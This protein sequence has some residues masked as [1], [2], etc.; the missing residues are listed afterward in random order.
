[1]AITHN[2]AGRVYTV[3]TS[4]IISFRDS[5]ALSLKPICVQKIVFQPTA[6]TNTATLY[7]LNTAA[8]PDLSISPLECVVTGNDKF[9]DNVG[10]GFTATSMAVITSW[11]HVTDSTSGNNN[12][13]YMLKTEDAG[14]DFIEVYDTAINGVSSHT[15]TDET[16]T[17]T[18]KFYTAEVQDVLTSPAVDNREVIR[19]WGDKGRYFPNLAVG[20]VTGTMYIHYK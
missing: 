2:I 19:N 12:G 10:T 11:V 9:T 16:S 17:Y 8:S 7:T 15:L 4:D 6:A 5:T 20:A 14:N 3:T 13:W 1:M 18:F